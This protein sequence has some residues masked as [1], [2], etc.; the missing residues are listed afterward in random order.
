VL[1][2][3]PQVLRALALYCLKFIRAY[4]QEG[5]DV[6]QLHV[7]NEPISDQKFPSCQWNGQRMR[8]FIR[9][10]AGPLFK[11]EGETC[12]LWLGTMNTLDYDRW[13][14][15]SLADEQARSY[16]RGV[17][18]QWEGQHLAALVHHAWPEMP[19]IQTENEC[20]DGSNS[21]GFALYMARLMWRYMTGGCRAYTY[22]NMVL[23][24][25]GRST[26]GWPQNAMVTVDPQS[27]SVTYNPDYYLMKHLSRY[28][29]PGAVRCRT[30]G[31]MATNAM[32]FRN[33][34]GSCV[35]LA[36]NPLPETQTLIL[37]AGGKTVAAELPPESVHTLVI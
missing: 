3:E 1:R 32:A 35:T 6:R 16:I 8:E 7:Q 23:P 33:G 17:G 25:G 36:Y 13:V 30:T 2:W 18:V 12:E 5:I 24:P 21:W 31:A 29:Q 28:V 20:S 27:K 19:I 9:D 34:D 11:A 26:W 14:L 37:Q 22:W 10:Y 15:P 4:R